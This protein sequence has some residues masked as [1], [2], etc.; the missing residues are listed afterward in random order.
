MKIGYAR[1]VTQE[2][3]TNLQLDSSE[4]AGCE[5]TFSGTASGA[6]KERGHRLRVARPLYTATTLH[7][8]HFVEIIEC[9]AP[10]PFTGVKGLKAE[11][12]LLFIAVKGVK[13]SEREIPFMIDIAAK[14]PQSRSGATSY[15][16]CPSQNSGISI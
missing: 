6:G 9:F 1:V 7:S 3:S 4:K 8:L 2:Q 11:F 16:R 13:S 15:S 10:H 12:P 14:R 5:R